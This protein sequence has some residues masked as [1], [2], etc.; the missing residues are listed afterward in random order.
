MD[1]GK[2]GELRAAGYL[3]RKGLRVIRTNFRCRFGEIDVIAM[4]GDT[5]CFIEVKTRRGVSHGL[6]SEA[7]GR[8][9]LLHIKKCAQVYLSR[10]GLKYESM[11]ID[12]VEVLRIRGRFYFRHLKNVSEGYL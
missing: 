2:E 5:I 8:T 1:I 9:K 10:S 4:D 12:V 6:P 7:V 3:D 11:R